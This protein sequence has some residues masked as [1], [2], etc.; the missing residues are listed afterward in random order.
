[1][2]DPRAITN[3]HLCAGPGAGQRGFLGP[4]EPTGAYLVDEN[5]SGATAWRAWPLTEDL[6]HGPEQRRPR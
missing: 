2:S 6:V 3:Q 4:G 5:L 1:M